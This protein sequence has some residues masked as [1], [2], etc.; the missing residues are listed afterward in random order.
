MVS[1]SFRTGWTRRAIVRREAF[2]PSNQRCRP[3]Y[4]ADC[5]ERFSKSVGDGEIER[6][7]T[8]KDTKDTA[9]LAIVAAARIAFYGR[10]GFL[11]SLKNLILSE[12]KSDR[13]KGSVG[14]HPLK[15]NSR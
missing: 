7:L 10:S 1:E 9:R 4:G 11:N 12:C 15:V 6:H 13:V 5:K 8:A 14:D 3:N 2:Q